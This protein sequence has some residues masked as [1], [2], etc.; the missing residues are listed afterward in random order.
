MFYLPATFNN[1]NRRII[2]L[3]PLCLLPVYSIT[4]LPD[5]IMSRLVLGLINSLSL[6]HLKWNVD[7]ACNKK[8]KLMGIWFSLL[9]YPI[10]HLLYYSSR[11]LPNFI[12]LP[13]VNLAIAQ[14][15]IGDINRSIFTR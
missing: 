13:I 14:F 2:V 10:F 4:K 12:A 9:T 3:L 5:L 7:E 8:S 11:T 1:F 15:V 6:I